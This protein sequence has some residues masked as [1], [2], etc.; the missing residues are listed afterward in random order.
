MAKAKITNVNL[1][2]VGGKTFTV[3][4][5]HAEKILRSKNNAKGLI[6]LDDKNFE[7]TENELRKRTIKR[8]NPESNK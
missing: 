5:V 4:L 7:L 6:V 8:D 3:T 1:K 2:T